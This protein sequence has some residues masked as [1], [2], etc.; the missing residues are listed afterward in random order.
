MTE[1]RFFIYGRGNCP[2]CVMACDLLVA[3]ERE[4]VFFNHQDDHETLQYLKEFYNHPT[5]P[6]VLENDKESGKTSFIGGYT[7]LLEKVK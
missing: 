3:L 5:F 6:M 4:F 2:F 7:D 1:E